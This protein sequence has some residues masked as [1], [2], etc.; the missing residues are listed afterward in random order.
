MPQTMPFYYLHLLTFGFLT[1]G[2]MTFMMSKYILPS[3]L[4]L[5]LARLMMMKL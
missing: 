3:V 2:L 4:K 5:Y 1:L